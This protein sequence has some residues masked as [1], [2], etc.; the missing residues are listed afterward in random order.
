MVYA[1]EAKRV[2]HLQIGCQL[3][4]YLPRYGKSLAHIAY[5]L[6]KMLLSLA[7]QPYGMHQA[8]TYTPQK[9]ALT[10]P[11]RPY[12]IATAIPS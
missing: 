4:V 1:K 6:S 2:A 3:M 9:M 11:Q 5:C 7:M 12:L 8:V 10:P